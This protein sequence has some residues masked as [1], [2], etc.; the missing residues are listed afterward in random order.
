VEEKEKE[1]GEEEREEE[2]EE[3]GGGRDKTHKNLCDFIQR[4]VALVEVGASRPHGELQWSLLR[5]VEAHVREA[6]VHARLGSTA[7][8]QWDVRVFF[9]VL[10]DPVTHLTQAHLVRNKS[11]LFC[12]RLD[13]GMFGSEC[14]YFRCPVCR[15]FHPASVVEQAGKSLREV[16]TAVS[17]VAFECRNLFREGTKIRYYFIGSVSKRKMGRQSEI[18]QGV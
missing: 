7:G 8:K 1:V 14:W 12:Q 4:A 18:R 5:N 2:K 10:G 13:R 17:V 16:K 3:G 11:F 6:S 9:G 15:A